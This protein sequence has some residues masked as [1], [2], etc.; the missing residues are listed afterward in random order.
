MRAV[1][2]LAEI[3]DAL[4]GLGLAFGEAERGQQQRREDADDRDDHEQFNQR[5]GVLSAL[6]HKTQPVS[7]AAESITHRRAVQPCGG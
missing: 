3:A 4:D 5:E 6:S 7:V 2:N 1:G